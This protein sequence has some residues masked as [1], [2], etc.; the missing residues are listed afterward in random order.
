LLLG[1][2]LNHLPS[3][4]FS[5]E[6][7]HFRAVA[8]NYTMIEQPCKDPKPHQFDTFLLAKLPILEICALSSLAFVHSITLHLSAG[9]K[10]DACDC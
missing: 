5:A 2:H 9:D 6:A 10:K 3:F 1:N 4:S 7:P 8:F